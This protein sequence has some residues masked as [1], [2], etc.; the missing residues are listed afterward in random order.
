MNSIA[1]ATWRVRAQQE[2]EAAYAFEALARS[3]KDHGAP[4][5]LVAAAR[6]SITDEERHAVLCGELVTSFGGAAEP[7]APR[8]Q[9]IIRPATR[10]ELLH[11]VV[12]LCCITETLSTVLLTAMLERA[13]HA[14]VAEVL[15]EVV[16]DEITHSRIGWG[17]LSTVDVAAD[18][19]AIAKALPG[20]LA[21]TV[22]SDVFEPDADAHLASELEGLGCLSRASISLL[23]CETLNEVIWPGLEEAGID[24]ASARSWLVS[25][26]SR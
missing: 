12:A 23:F 10:A 9:R 6:D 15:R 21:G 7:S 18:A 4:E 8:P 24:T 17:Y 13:K 20:M 25:I 5:V 16:R 2:R 19:P 1:A 22:S 3:L 11:E 14:G 26:R